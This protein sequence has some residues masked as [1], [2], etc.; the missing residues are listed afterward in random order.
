MLAALAGSDPAAAR[1]LVADLLSI[2]GIKA[3]G[4][5]TVA[6]IAERFLEQAEL[7][8]A[9][10]LPAETMAVLERY[11]AIVGD[12]DEASAALRTLASD[13]ALDLSAPLDAFEQRSGFLAAG[14]VDVTGIRFATAFGRTLDYYSGMVF[15][16]HAKKKGRAREEM[17][18]PLAAGGRYDRL[19]TLLGSADP[20]PAVGFAVWIERLEQA[21]GRP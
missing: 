21:G 6:E 19:L 3:V 9:T 20:V 12:P 4:G 7:G 11:L 14:G 13:A 2:A 1:A 17:L 15:E 10:R 5:R 18:G 8:A 16:I